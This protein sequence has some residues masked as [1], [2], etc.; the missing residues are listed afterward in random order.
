M[1]LA[2]LVCV[3][4]DGQAMPAVRFK[5]DTLENDHWVMSAHPGPTFGRVELK[6]YDRLRAGIA[7]ASPEDIPLMGALDERARRVRGAWRELP[8]PTAFAMPARVELEPVP[9]QAPPR[10]PAP[11]RAP[12]AQ[13]PAPPALEPAR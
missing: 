9:A 10:A 5:T 12:N 2:S 4:R 1:R 3:D 11:G 7:T 8:L 6:V 13:P